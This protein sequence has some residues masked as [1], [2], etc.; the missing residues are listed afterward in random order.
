MKF[1]EVFSLF[2][3]ALYPPK[4]VFCGT[5]ISPGTALCEQ[6]EEKNPP[7]YE[8]RWLPLEGQKQGLQCKVL[9]HYKLGVKQAILDFKFHDKPEN[10]KFFAEKMKDFLLLSY[11]T[12]QIDCTTVVPISKQRKKERGYNQSEMLAKYFMK[13][14]GIPY[15]SCLEKKKDNEEQHKLSAKER[16]Q[17]VIGV[18]ICP[19][20]EIVLGKTILLLDDIVTTGHTLSECA[21]TLY[22]AGAKL[23]VCAAIATSP[24]EL[25]E[26]HS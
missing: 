10:S 11:N 6:C 1:K 17:N 5:T 24:P 16:K 23:V 2:L 4:C 19:N 26:C 25:Y 7:I 9:Y 8:E 13:F 12:L 15:I 18:Y 3:D 14:S 21:H 20:H 22:V